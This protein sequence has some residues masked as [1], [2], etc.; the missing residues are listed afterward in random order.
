MRASEVEKLP[1]PVDWF[2]QNGNT[3]KPSLSEPG[4]AAAVD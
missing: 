1:Q 3:A 2:H 4:L